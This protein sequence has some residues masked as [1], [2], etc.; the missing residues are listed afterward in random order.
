MAV[1]GFWESEIFKV[2]DRY[3]EDY[4]NYPPRSRLF[5]GIKQR[6]SVHD[7][8]WFFGNWDFPSLPSVGLCKHCSG[9][10]RNIRIVPGEDEVL[11]DGLRL[12]SAC[13]PSR[14]TLGQ[15]NNADNQAV[16][17]LPVKRSVSNNESPHQL[18][19]YHQFSEDELRG[20]ENS[21][22]YHSESYEASLY[23]LY[24]DKE[25]DHE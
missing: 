24:P 15:P 1:K 11:V 21:I 23:H 7:M 20:A 19:E 18:E 5:L 3:Y 12:D 6:Y 4:G 8:A 10:V 16:F 13:N 9:E 2:N 14:H 22:N 17:P 25:E